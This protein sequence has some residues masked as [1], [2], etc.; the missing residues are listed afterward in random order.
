MSDWGTAA[1]I[2]KWHKDRG[3]RGIGYH[4]VILNGYP[5]FH[6]YSKKADGLIEIGRP[7]ER[8]GAHCRGHNRDSVGICLIGNRLFSPR[9][10]FFSLPKVVIT[11]FEE[12]NL[13][14]NDVYGHCDFS[15]TK[16]CPN[17][18]MMQIKD[19][20]FDETYKYREW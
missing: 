15:K 17:I 9:Q 13:S 11:L 7:I 1:I 8:I 10:L 20:L 2:D 14:L 19:I 12:F 3:W 4:Y 16:T 6:C 5:K 18:P